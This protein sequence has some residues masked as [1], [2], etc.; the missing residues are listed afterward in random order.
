[1]QYVN[2][3]VSLEKVSVGFRI[4][5][6]FMPFYVY[7]LILQMLYISFLRKKLYLFVSVMLVYIC[8]QSR[9]VRSHLK[10]SN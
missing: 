3:F 8:T 10:W 6:C 2:W 5:I 4:T 7:L 9:E 1:M